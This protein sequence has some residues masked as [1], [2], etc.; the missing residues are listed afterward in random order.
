MLPETPREWL[1]WAI[2][3]A[4]GQTALAAKIGVKQ[5]IVFGWLHKTRL[6]VPAEKCQA[7]EQATGIPK[8]KLRP[9]IFG[10]PKAA[11]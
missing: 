10:E 9:D 11:A 5:Q 1:Q 2:A 8:H 6:G 4:G 7:I 3:K